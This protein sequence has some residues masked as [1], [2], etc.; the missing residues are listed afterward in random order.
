MTWPWESRSSIPQHS[1]GYQVS[2]FKVGGNY[3]GVEYQQ[4]RIVGGC[5]ELAAT[6]G[7]SDSPTGLLH[8]AIR[9]VVS[10]TV[11][12]GVRG[13]SETAGIGGGG[14]ARWGYHTDWRQ[15][16]YHRG[17]C[18]P[19]SQVRGKAHTR[20]SSLLGKHDGRLGP[21]GTLLKHKPPRKALGERMTR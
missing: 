9:P 21:G 17:S 14:R 1:A 10:G 16:L 19:L 12:S 2:L 15:D 7:L 6:P 4:A 18:G 3:T 5:L 20:P 8:S 11:V 13:V